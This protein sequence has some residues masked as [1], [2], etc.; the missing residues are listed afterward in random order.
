MTITASAPGLASAAATVTISPGAASQLT[1]TSS[2]ADLATGVSRTLTAAV[3]DASGNVVV[4]DNSTLVTFGQSAG[5]GSLNGLGTGTAV[6]GVASR[7]VTGGT[8]GSV[9]ASAAASGLTP[10]TSVFNVTSIPTFSD[11]PV[12]AA[13]TAIKAVHISELRDSIDALRARF[14]LTPMS[15]TDPTLTTGVTQIKAVHLTELRSALN[16]VYVAAGRTPPTY[17]NASVAA[18]STLIAAVNINELRAAVLAI[19]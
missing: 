2:T 17:S 10:G 6:S 19:W 7:T 5:S 3:R 1:F 8:A 15:W 12:T 9:T 11:N 18:G 16:A 14:S 13:S 4:T